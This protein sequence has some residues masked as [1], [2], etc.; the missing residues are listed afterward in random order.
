MDTFL[1]NL[2]S[3]YAEQRAAHA[4]IAWYVQAGSELS[5]VPTFPFTAH[6]HAES[7]LTP[8]YTEVRGWG[9]AEAELSAGQV[10]PLPHSPG[11]GVLLE[12]VPMN[13]AP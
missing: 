4:F 13:G 2:K 5:T 8:V 10:C 9:Q 1:K 6:Q 12:P 3:F 7:S 11:L